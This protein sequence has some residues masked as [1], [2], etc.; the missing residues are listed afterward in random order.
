MAF[1]LPMAQSSPGFDPFDPAF[2]RNPYPAYAELRAH[3]PVHFHPADPAHDRP[4][5]FALSRYEDIVAAVRAPEDFSSANGLTFYADEI[6]ALGLAPTLVMM[7]PPEHSL[8]RRLVASGFSPRR[9]AQTEDTIREFARGRLGEIADRAA[10]GEAIDIHTGYSTTIP[11]FVLGFLLG[12]PAADRHLLDPWVTALTTIQDNG[13]AFG[14]LG[15]SAVDAV[16]D[17]FEYFGALIADRRAE[18]GAGTEVP[19]DLITGLLRAEYEGEHLTDW[20]VLGFCFVIV[21]GGNDTTGNLISHTIAQ[22]TEYPDQRAEVA[23]DPALIPGAL[24]ECLRRESSVQALARTT[25]RELRISDVIIP[26]GVKVMMYYGSG[27]RDERE[28]GADAAELDI[29]REFIS[30]LAFS[31]GPH[32]CIGSHFAKLQ[33][34][35]ALEELYEKFPTISA[36]AGRADR[37]ESPFTRGFKNLFAF[38]LAAR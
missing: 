32:F 2:L 36:D 1:A 20:D 12:I 35:V 28:F 19:D 29:H 27:N 24:L 7:D 22:L 21:A 38:D 10:S 8:K 18:L 4:E 31:Q 9:V 23:A 16:A 33:A 30:H 13:F 11:T 26:K 5:F 25:T 14:G 6:A 34:R 17:M 37:I 15:T 3:D